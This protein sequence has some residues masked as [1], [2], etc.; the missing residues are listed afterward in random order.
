VTTPG[1]TVRETGEKTLAT[2]RSASFHYNL[3]ERHEAGLALRG[4][5]VKSVRAGKAALRDAYV[6]FRGNEAWLVNCHIPEYTPGGTWNHAPMRDRKLLLHRSEIIKL[7]VKVQQ[8]G[9]TVL[10]VRLYLKGGRV[11]C[12]IALARGKK[13]WDRRATIRERE[14]RREAARAIHES[15]SRH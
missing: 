8:K 5:E 11:K 12:E 1:K 13:E 4:T 3:L 6:V 15:K 7:G 10:A 14:D 9:L 2:N